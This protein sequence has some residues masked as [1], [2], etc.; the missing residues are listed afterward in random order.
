MK[1]VVL[2]FFAIIIYISVNA[3]T[4]YYV[5]TTGSDSD[6]GTSSAPFA[7]WQKAIS[8]VSAG[9]TIII[10]EGTYYPGADTDNGKLPHYGVYINGIDGTVSAHITLKSEREGVRPVLDC[11]NLDSSSTNRGLVINYSDYWNI[12]GVDITGVNQVNTSVCAGLIGLYCNYVHLLGVRSYDNEGVGIRFEHTCTGVT[13]ENCDSYNNYDYVSN[14]NHADGIEFAYVDE[15]CHNYIKGCRIWNNSDDGID[16][17]QNDGIMEIDSCWVWNNGKDDGDGNGFKM[18]KSTITPRPR[19]TYRYVRNCLAAYNKYN[20]LTDNNAD[21]KAEVCNNTFYENSRSVQ[22]YTNSQA[23]IFQN[24]LYINN[25]KSADYGSSVTKNDLSYTGL[26]EFSLLS[27]YAAI[28][29]VE[30]RTA[31]GFNYALP[32]VDFLRPL[33]SNTAVVDQGTNVGLYYIRS[34]PD[35]GYAE[36]GLE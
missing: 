27:R 6:V 3:Q 17:W 29:T 21:M 20:A 35:Y 15:G 34:A 13:I 25:T 12:I 19:I 5:S 1:K 28:D 7:T 24:N 30:L 10:R 32:F 23:S 11:S 14:G 31:R 8:K 18:G 33:E 2:L 9:D 4:T 22:F 36:Y 16:L 26:S